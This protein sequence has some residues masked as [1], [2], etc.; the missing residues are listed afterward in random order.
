[1]S[2]NDTKNAM[3][4]VIDSGLE[5]VHETSCLL[6]RAFRKLRYDKNINYTTWHTLLNK[7]LLKI[8]KQY[9]DK[10]RVSLKGNITRSIAKKTLTWKYFIRA[11][12][13]LEY[14]WMEVHIRL[15]KRNKVDEVKITIQDLGAELNRSSSEE[16]ED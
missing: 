10:E 15:G 13:I 2:S 9:T 1:M 4:A 7:H 11:V 8:Q 16:D 3:K 5:G 6:A 14:E 12:T